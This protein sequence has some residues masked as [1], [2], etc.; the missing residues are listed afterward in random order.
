MA[1]NL[2]VM[3]VKNKIPF[4]FSLSAHLLEEERRRAP[5]REGRGQ[6]LLGIP[7]VMADR[8]LESVQ[9]NKVGKKV[10]KND[11]CLKVAQM[12]VNSCC[13]ADLQTCRQT[14]PTSQGSLV[15]FLLCKSTIK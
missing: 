13:L 6:D 14:C 12:C 10:N 8:T 1:S 7:S 3:E 4:G 9:K 15:L 5:K 11:S 2:D